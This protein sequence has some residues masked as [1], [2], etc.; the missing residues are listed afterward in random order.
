MQ[1]KE[2]VNLP[3]KEAPVRYKLLRNYD[4]EMLQRDVNQ[5]IA[6]GWDPLGAPVR[7]AG[8]MSWRWVQAVV[9]N[10]PSI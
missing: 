1:Q 9:F 10:P 6:N 5:H 7:N 8:G 2:V 3:S 4:P